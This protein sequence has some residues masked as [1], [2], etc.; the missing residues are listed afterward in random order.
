MSV[1]KSS[2]RICPVLNYSTLFDREQFDKT[3][4][5]DTYNKLIK[6]SGVKL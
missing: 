6:S 1:S 4:V 2:R 3:I 5:T